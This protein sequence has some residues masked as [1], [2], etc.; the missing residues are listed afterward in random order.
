MA[1]G[2]HVAI[3]G[4]TGAVGREFINVLEERDFP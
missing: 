1:Q 2:Y 3:L 4:A